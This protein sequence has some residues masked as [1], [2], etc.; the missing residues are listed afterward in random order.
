MSSLT[1]IMS[2]AVGALQ[3]NQGALNGTANNVANVNTPGYSRKRAILQENIPVVLGSLTFGTGVTLERLESLR[4]PILQL[5]IQQETQQQGSLNSFVPSMQQAEVMFNNNSGGDIGTLMSNFF[6]SLQ[7]LSA[8]PANLA[9]RQ[10]V[11]TAAGNLAKGFN[12]TSA[13]LSSQRTNIDLSVVQDVQQ[14]NT[15]TGQ[16]A[17]VN[18]Q[19][20]ALEA[21]GGDAGSFI[22]QRDQLTG[23]L[24]QLIDVSSIKSDNGVTLTTSN[25][26]PLVAAGQSFSLTLQTDPTGVQHIYSQG[27]DIT[28]K[29]SAGGLAGLLEVRDVKIPSLIFNLDTLAAGVAAAIN[30]ANQAGF[31]LSGTA[32]A[33]IFVPPPVSAVGAAANLAVAI[34]DPALIA[35]SS[36]GRPGSNGNVAALIAVHDQ[37]VAGGQTPT[38]Y[39]SSIVFGIGSDVS[40]GISEQQA[41]S[42]VL[43]QLQDQ[44]GSISGVSLDE[45]ASNMLRYQ[46]AYNASARLV[47]TINEML[48]TVVNLGR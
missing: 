39:Y 8:D 45:E 14:V 41:S 22:D 42:L 12:T 26:S 28:S 20:I 40:N 30:T 18:N 46:Q 25:G 16:I 2:L 3:A 1:S 13:N 4:D 6:T 43:Q 38:D 37:T 9:V 29:L 27:H 32:G 19:I 23:Q 36:D 17:K 7:Q 24:S 31:D 35:A 21:T 48:T 33:N 47:S 10:T 44:R 34:T 11:L 15:L 5:R